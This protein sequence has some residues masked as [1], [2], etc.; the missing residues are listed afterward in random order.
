MLTGKLIDKIDTSEVASKMLCLIRFLHA[1]NG[2]SINGVDSHKYTYIRKHFFILLDSV[3]SIA[4]LNDCN[5]E[6]AEL[7]PFSPYR[8]LILFMGINGSLK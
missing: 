8:H 3:S 1:Y 2:Y 6:L 7:K 5:K 4:F